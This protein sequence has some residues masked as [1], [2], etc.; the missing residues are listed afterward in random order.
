MGM[1]E[2]HVPNGPHGAPAGA[3]P[4]ACHE[5][6]LPDETAIWES[7]WIDLGGEG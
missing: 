1:N 2:R 3:E 7:A 5:N 6:P 4:P